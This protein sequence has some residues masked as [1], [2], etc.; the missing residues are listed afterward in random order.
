MIYLLIGKKKF[1]GF[2]SGSR[3][4][5]QVCVAVFNDD[6]DAPKDSS[7]ESDEVIDNGPESKRKNSVQTKVF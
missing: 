5:S 2:L 4:Q 7:S 6:V 1:N 3:P